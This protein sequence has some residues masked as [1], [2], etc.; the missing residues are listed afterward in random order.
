MM[1]RIHIVGDELWLRMERSVEKVRQRLERAASA[2][3]GARIPYALVGGNAVGVWVAQ[4]DE[5]AVRTTRDV[6][7]LLRRDD[8]TAAIEALER[9][10]FH[11]RKSAGVTM[12]LDGAEATAR[13]AVHIVFANEKVL[14]DYVEA[15]PDVDECEYVND[16]RTLKLQSLVRMK[17]TSF[18]DRDRTHLRD[19][20]E[21]GLIDATWL[22]KVSPGL[23]TR[24]QQL[25]DTP[26]G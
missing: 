17:L 20:L 16:F 2:L 6:D 15:A 9:T 22:E 21:V 19:M 24:L 11:Y 10:G 7:I 23:R 8:L 4:V 26:L 25:I 5:A 3:E 14:P 12:F 1:A 13:D 18:R